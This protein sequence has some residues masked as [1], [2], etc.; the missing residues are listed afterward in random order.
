MEGRDCVVAPDGL[1]RIGFEI[2]FPLCGLGPA[3]SRLSR[4]NP[5]KESD[6]REEHRVYRGE[7]NVNA[8]S[9]PPDH[10]QRPTEEARA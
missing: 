2:T 10:D 5:S 4:W 7:G 3:N 6:D 9:P 8:T 1:G